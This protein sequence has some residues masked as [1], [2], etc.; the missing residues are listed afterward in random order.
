MTSGDSARL[1]AGMIARRYCP[2]VPRKATWRLHAPAV[3][4][5][6]GRRQSLPG[7][8]GRAGRSP[9]LGPPRI[10]SATTRERRMPNYTNMGLVLLLALLNGGEV[11]AIAADIARVRTVSGGELVYLRR[12]R[13]RLP[14]PTWLSKCPSTVTGRMLRQGTQRAR[15]RRRLVHELAPPVGRARGRSGAH[16]EAARPGAAGLAR[17][18]RRIDELMVAPYPGPTSDS[19]S[20]EWLFFD[21]TSR[22]AWPLVKPHPRALEPTICWGAGHPLHSRDSAQRLDP[23]SPG[24]AGRPGLPHGCGRRDDGETKNAMWRL[25]PAV[26]KPMRSQP[27]RL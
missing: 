8:L 17:R 20:M 2:L 14:K 24:C 10:Y 3:H 12:P 13:A 25:Q 26:V 15:P 21:A 18:H 1:A 4:S 7:A 6:A 23:A 5:G 9:G 22:R 19:T 16:A 11:V 27:P